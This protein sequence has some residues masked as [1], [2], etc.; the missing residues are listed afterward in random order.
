MSHSFKDHLT[1]DDHNGR[2]KHV[3]GCT[4]CNKST[5]LFQYLL[6]ISHK[7]STVQFMN[8]F[9]KYIINL[10]TLTF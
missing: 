3:A 7:E 10:C 5:Y 6:V 8:H 9:K 2:P 4:E 1:E